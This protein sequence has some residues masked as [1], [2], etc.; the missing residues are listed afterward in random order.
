MNFCGV[1]SEQILDGDTSGSSR[2]PEPRVVSR[3]FRCGGDCANTL[4]SHEAAFT[5]TANLLSVIEDEDSSE[6]EEDEEAD[7]PSAKMKKNISSATNHQQQQHPLKAALDNIQQTLDDIQNGSNNISGLPIEAADSPKKTSAS[8][9]NV[10][11]TPS[12]SPCLLNPLIDDRKNSTATELD[13]KIL[14]PIFHTNEYTS[15]S[16]GV[17]VQRLEQGYSVHLVGGPISSLTGDGGKVRLFLQEDHMRFC[18]ESSAR[19]NGDAKTDGVDVGV[20]LPINAILRLEIG[21]NPKAFTM[22]LEK[23]RGRLLYYDFE[24][25]TTID[26]EVIATSIMLLLDQTY[27]PFYQDEVGG[28]SWTGGTE[29][30]PI[31]CSPSLE[32]DSSDEFRQLSPRRSTQIFNTAEDQETETSLVIHLEDMTVAESDIST[33][34]GEYWSCREVPTFNLLPRKARSYE[35][36]DTRLDCKPSASSTQLGLNA[37]NS[38]NLTATVWCPADSCAF[39]LNDIADTC[40]GIF[41]LKQAES[42]CVSIEQQVVVEEFIASALGAPTAVY[43]YLTER[44][45]W[46]VESSSSMQDSSKD[47]R[48]AVHRNRASLLNAQAARLR[49]LRNEMTFAAAL[50]HSKERMRFIQTVQSFDDAYARSVGTKKLKAATEAANRFHA[51]ALLQSVIG[52]MKMHDTNGNSKDDEEGVAFYDSD[53]E[54]SRPSNAKK[55]PRQVAATCNQNTTQTMPQYQLSSCP[56]FDEIGSGKKVSKKLDEETIVDIVQVSTVLLF[57]C[58]VGPSNSTHQINYQFLLQTMNNERLTLMWHPTQT[59]N[60]RNRSPIC[61]RVWIES[62]VYLNDGTFLL[63]KLTWSKASQDDPLKQTSLET[64]E[65][66]DICRIRPTMN[67]DR[68]LHPFA[69]TQKSF[70]LETQTESFVFQAQTIEERDRIVYG[71]KLVVARL[72]SLLMLRDIRAA[73]EFFG[74]SSVPGEAPTT[75]WMKERGSDSSAASSNSG[76]TNEY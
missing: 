3:N 52:N 62:G 58:C 5:P 14:C 40:T 36:E 1:D 75:A 63:P 27:N 13:N 8:P 49:G 15:S 39:A 26:R 17:V 56:G 29:E 45:I 25:A 55:G 51:S 28:E 43:T 71:L 74:S 76:G 72:A 47:A 10:K 53:P 21:S 61:V 35:Q 59:T 4:D 20:E 46:N 73:D 30:Q 16:I 66:L 37:V 19:A 33:K 31:P 23:Q 44:D 69:L 50:K 2:I 65:L 24:A 57:S 38:A 9:M 34:G 42:S 60:D 18:V 70:Y 11:S 67:I 22:V 41:A 64:I 6:E 48:D 7:A 54:D 68:R 12:P 32:N